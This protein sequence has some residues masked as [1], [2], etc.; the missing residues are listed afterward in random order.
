MGVA[1]MDERDLMLLKAAQEGI[2]LTSRPYQ[3]LGEKL[4]SKDLV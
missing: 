1:L 4:I 2:S 3:A